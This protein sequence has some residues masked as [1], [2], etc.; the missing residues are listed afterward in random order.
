VTAQNVLTLLFFLLSPKL[1]KNFQIHLPLNGTQAKA[2]PVFC[3]FTRKYAVTIL[4][5]SNI[6]GIF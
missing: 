6:V 4:S 5:S 3:I 2:L 1:A